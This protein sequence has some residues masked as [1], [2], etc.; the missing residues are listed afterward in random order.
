MLGKGEREPLRKMFLTK[1]KVSGEHNSTRKQFRQNS[2]NLF[3]ITAAH[4]ETILA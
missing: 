1:S 3:E 2:K 4:T